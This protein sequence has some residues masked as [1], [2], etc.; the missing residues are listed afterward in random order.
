LET[1]HAALGDFQ[2]MSERLLRFHPGVPDLLP[3]ML[4]GGVIAFG[5]YSVAITS[6][7]RKA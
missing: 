7:K 1:Y 4:L 3:W 5:L 2:V 6:A